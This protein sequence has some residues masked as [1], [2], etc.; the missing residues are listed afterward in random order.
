MSWINSNTNLQHTGHLYICACLKPRVWIFVYLLLEPAPMATEASSER[1]GQVKSLEMTLFQK[2][3]SARGTRQFKQSAIIKKTS[4]S[5]SRISLQTV[6]TDCL[7]FPAF[8]DLLSSFLR[9]V[10]SDVCRLHSSSAHYQISSEQPTNSATPSRSRLNNKVVFNRKQH[11]LTLLSGLHQR[12]TAELPE[13]PPET[14]E[15]RQHA[16]HRPSGHSGFLGC[17]APAQLS[18]AEPRARANG[19]AL[20]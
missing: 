14:V 9:L 2:H 17:H 8:S 1:A 4:C 16:Q 7:T 19:L 15:A 5:N 20:L 12:H 18:W 10:N 3:C 11:G 6:S 13:Q